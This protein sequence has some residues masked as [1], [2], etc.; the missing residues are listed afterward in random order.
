M[1]DAGADEQGG[2]PQHRADVRGA[3]LQ[4]VECLLGDESG[5]HYAGRVAE[6][7]DGWVMLAWLERDRDG[8]FL[9]E[10]SDPMPLCVEPDG[11]LR[12]DV[13]GPGPG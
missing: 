13:D 5:R 6:T 8:S 9:G 7:P 4:R 2:E 11:Q 3:S 10:L 12:V 1:R